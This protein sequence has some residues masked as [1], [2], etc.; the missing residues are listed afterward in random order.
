M[1]RVPGIHTTKQRKNEVGKE[2]AG[3]IFMEKEKQ[4]ILVIDDE[5][6]I[7][8]AC[9]QILKQQGHDV[10]FA[11][12][13]DAGLECFSAFHP[14]VIFV[15][16]KMPGISG[17][18]VL[19]KIR[20]QDKNVVVVIIT[21]YATIDSAVESMQKG[22]FDF[23]PKPFSQEELIILTRRALQRKRE[24]LER[25]HLIQE[26]ERMRQNFI[27]LVSHELR[28]PMVAVMQY[29]EL[30]LSGVPGEVTERQSEI[31]G[32]MKIRLNELLKLIDR[33]LRLSRIEELKIKEG[34][35]EVSLKP[36]VDE[37]IDIVKSQAGDKDITIAVEHID[38]DCVVTGDR[39]MIKE[40][41]MNLLTNGIKYNRTGGTVKISEREQ[42]GYY[43][44]DFS[45]TGIGIPCS[46]IEQLGKEF[47]RIH[48]EGAAAGSG[49]GLAIVKKILD[50]HGGRLEIQSQKQ[51]GSTFSVV[52]PKY[53][54]EIQDQGE[55]DEKNENTDH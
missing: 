44:F 6:V 2:K 34:F 20:A 16:L 47:Y 13:G 45:D 33:W 31:Y 23:L 3:M 29:V 24:N 25:Q 26:K 19:E 43:I 38:N 11:Q 35:S 9:S 4:K 42:D 21:G 46:E 32:R 51:K 52:L 5:E 39:D 50:I 10:Q 15:D 22:A 36:L 55:K 49:L 37:A 12:D 1:P 27:S 48:T 8:D 40:V 30:L 54:K 41:F 18:E 7:C 28:T 17:I 53:D 14:D